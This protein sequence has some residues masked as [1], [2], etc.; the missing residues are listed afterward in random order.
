[1][2]VL[3][4][5]AAALA[6]GGCR[7]SLDHVPKDKD[8]ALTPRQIYDKG[9]GLM[10][11]GRYFR[12]REVLEKV[13]GRTN[14]GP[15]LLADTTLAIADAYYYDGGVINVAEAL[16]RYT[17]FLT[18]YPTHPRADYAQYQLGMSY[19]KQALGPDKDQS[20]TRDALDAFRKVELNHPASGFVTAAR[21]KADECRERLAET[22]VRV[23]LFYL[24]REAWAGAADR[25][26][27]V[28]E[29]YPRYS[30]RDRVYFLLAQALKGSNKLPEAQ[31][32]FQKVLDEYPASRYAGQARQAL[33][34]GDEDASG[35]RAEAPKEKKSSA[36]LEPASPSAAGAR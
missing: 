9:V 25:F 24:K 28:L 1:M 23:G 7:K 4:L 16:S 29:S 8:A 20:T 21:E 34:A 17:S 18:F 12:A 30:R 11:R 36:V 27:T 33:A 2:G 15:E 19:L 10:R 31:I 14:A 5:A 32:Y 6:A 13:L 26:R 22:E 35:R 3:L